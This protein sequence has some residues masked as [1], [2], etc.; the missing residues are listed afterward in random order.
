M[1]LAVIHV[2]LCSRCSS[3][4]SQ[5]WETKCILKWKEGD[6]YAWLE[7]QGWSEHTSSL[8]VFRGNVLAARTR[9]RLVKA[10]KDDVVA[11]DLFT[12]VGLVLQDHNRRF[13]IDA[14]NFADIVASR[15]TFL[16]SSPDPIAARCAP[17]SILY[18]P[19]LQG[20]H[21]L[22]RI[23]LTAIT[24]ACHSRNCVLAHRGNSSTVGSR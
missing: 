9:E 11:E 21:Y 10:V 23:T 22:D 17:T 6:I 14:A 20:T 3:L 18:P 24:T 5:V 7:Y 16:H 8:K 4:A 19:L 12:A 13:D 15:G 1:C 2:S